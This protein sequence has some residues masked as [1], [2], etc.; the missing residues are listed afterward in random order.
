MK[1]KVLLK[2][3]AGLILI[4]LIGHAVGHTAWDKPADP[5]MMEVVTAMKNYEGEFMGAVH[6]MADYY[7][8]YSILIFGLY[9]MSISL[10]WLA[11]GFIQEHPVIANKILYPVGIAYLFFAI[12]EFMYFFPFAASISFLAGVLT[13]SSIVISKR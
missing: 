1:A 5:K 8:G 3:A 4:H 13:I 10:L 2:I 12:V 9:G 11:S 7:K 6:S